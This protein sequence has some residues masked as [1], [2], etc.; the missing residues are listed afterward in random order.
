MKTNWTTERI[1]QRTNRENDGTAVT[2][3]TVIAKRSDGKLRDMVEVEVTRDC[4]GQIYIDLTQPKED[5][6]KADFIVLKL[7]MLR[8]I[9][10]S[11]CAADSS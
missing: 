7:D 5:S 1:N 3:F 9:W 10:E 8:L 6:N 2:M 4:N 11:A